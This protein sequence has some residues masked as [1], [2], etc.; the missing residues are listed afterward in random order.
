MPL[1]AYTVV[2]EDGTSVSDET[3]AADAG[4]LRRD[5]EARGY[6]VLNIA[7]KKTGL[8]GGRGNAKD[9]LIF[10]QE[11]ITLVKA[12]LPILQ[13]LEIIRNR[14]EKQGFRTVL[15]SIIQEIKGGRALSDAMA[16]HPLYFSP[17]YTA[18]VRAGEKSGALVDVLKRFILYQKKMLAIRR[19]FITALAYPVFLVIALIAVLML[20]FLYIIPNFTQMYSDQAGKLPLL[21]TL[22]ISFTAT[23]TAYAPLILGALIAAGIGIYLW[24][25]TDAGRQV[26]DALE[27]RI[28]LVRT[29]LTQYILGQLTRTLAT[30]LRG[31]IPLVQSLDT[32][33][34]VIGNR[35]IA[36]R[37]TE[38]R[39]LVTE[40]TSLANA[41][42][43][44]R[45]APD[46]TVRMVEVGE[47]SGDLPQMLED[48]AEF[49]DQEV[50][51]R[52][53]VLTTMIEPVL[54]LSMG[55]VIAVIV[56]ALYLPIFEMGARL[57]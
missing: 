30:V 48:V 14:T 2:R 45:L 22:L 16:N 50:E 26:L 15:E 17:L 34:G 18:T 32:T 10:N 13:S 49:Y 41:F 24:Q 43:R 47:S 40:G 52:L 28:P 1:F 37:L 4:D 3:L 29:L 31:G 6:L 54:M 7:E 5:L 19:K 25:K 21:T 44:T 20:F 42:E 27:L 11:F 55:I 46:M 12:G 51:N 39:T 23:L 56:V 38:A 36:R 8:R 33:A 35:V 53:T 9:F 57:K